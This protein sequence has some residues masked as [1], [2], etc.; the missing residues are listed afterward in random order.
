MINIQAIIQINYC[1]KLILFL[2]QGGSSFD[3]SFILTLYNAES[4][5]CHF[6]KKYKS[7]IKNPRLTI[8]SAAHSY[9]VIELLSSEQKFDQYCDGLL[10]RFC[11]F[12]PQP[13]RSRLSNS[14]LLNHILPNG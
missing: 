6:T 4:T 7:S 1:I 9:N 8:L 2:I 13:R 5:L 10:A 14:Y 12:N 11:I 3:R